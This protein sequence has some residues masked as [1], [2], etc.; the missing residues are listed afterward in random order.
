MNRYIV[1]PV[2]I[3]LA[4]SKNAY[5][6]AKKE[7]FPCSVPHTY[8]IGSIDPRFHVTKNIVE[9]SLRNA[10]ALWEDALQKNLFTKEKNGAIVVN[11]I[12]DNRQK[13]GEK[14]K[15]LGGSLSATKAAYETLEREYEVKRKAYEE[16]EATLRQLLQT[17]SLRQRAYEDEMKRILARGV[18]ENDRKRMKSEM[19]AI[20]ADGRDIN[21]RIEQIGRRIDEVNANAKKLNALVPAINRIVRDYNANGS[22]RGGEFEAGNYVVD[23]SGKRIDIYVYDSESQLTRILAHEFGHALGIEHVEDKRAIMYAYNEGSDLTL[24]ASEIKK[25]REICRL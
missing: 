18:T 14:L 17:H 19:D 10:E 7:I 21:A 1:L 8:S 16:E 24:A 11:L 15:N 13:I 2:I 12:Y 20:N 9:T 22:E 3:V 23:R 6:A 25:L 4:G 5:E